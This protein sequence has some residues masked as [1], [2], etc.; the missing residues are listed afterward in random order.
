MKSQS[1]V[2]LSVRIAEEI[3]GPA[4]IAVFTYR[5]PKALAQKQTRSLNTKASAEISATG[6]N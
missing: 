5:L 6:T 1:A 4:E 3:F 2:L